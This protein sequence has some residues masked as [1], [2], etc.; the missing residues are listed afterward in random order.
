MNLESDSDEED[1]VLE[2][3][4]DTTATK[5]NNDISQNGEKNEAMGITNSHMSVS[6]E[7]EMT[8]DR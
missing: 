3:G 8:D 1:E 5:T 6:D 2:I 7:S 4:T